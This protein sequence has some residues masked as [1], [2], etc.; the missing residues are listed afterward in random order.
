MKQPFAHLSSTV[1]ALAAAIAVSLSVFLLSGAGLQGQPIPLLPALGGAADR[2]ALNL[3]TPGRERPPAPARTTVSTAQQVVPT[4][5]LTAPRPAAHKVHRAH[6]ARAREVRHAPPSPVQ[7]AVSAPAPTTPVAAPV[8][9]APKAN[10]KAHGHRQGRAGKPAVAGTH[11]HGNGHAR[12]HSPGHHQGLPPG[13][14]KKVPAAPPTAPPKA[15]G[16]GPPPDHGGGDG[17]KGD[18]K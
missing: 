17:H 9:S 10:A 3:A 11:R 7:V 4:A 5:R 13:Q 8:I 14:A 6:H 18:K 15:K 16:G 12:G 1:L 2:V